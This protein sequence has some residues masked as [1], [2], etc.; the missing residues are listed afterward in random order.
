MMRS[1]PSRRDD[2]SA[3]RPG[4]RTTRPGR[5]VQPD[6]K[7]GDLAGALDQLPLVVGVARTEKFALAEA[8][9]KVAKVMNGQTRGARLW[10]TTKDTTKALAELHA[11]RQL[12]TDDS[13]TGVLNAFA[14]P[15]RMC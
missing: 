12:R 3:G 9:D 15:G 5:A 11:V 13:T 14:T 10:V 4:G 8:S 1:G 2:R 6:Q 7:T